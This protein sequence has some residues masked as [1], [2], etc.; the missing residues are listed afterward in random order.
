[1]RKT[2]S[3]SLVPVLIAALAVATAGAADLVNA[4]RFGRVAIKGY[5][6]VA[7]FTEG[8]PVKGSK[9]HQLV[10]KGAGWPKLVAEK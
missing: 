3:R 5:D 7:Y 1:M 2:I 10:W 9:S 4:T 6:P 8:R